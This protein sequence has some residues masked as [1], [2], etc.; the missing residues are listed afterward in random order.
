ME[1]RDEPATVK[2]GGADS[3]GQETAQQTVSNNNKSV[4]NM[5]QG[6]SNIDKSSRPEAIGHVAVDVS[7]FEVDVHEPEDDKLESQSDEVNSEV[8]LGAVRRKIPRCPGVYVEGTVQ[9]IPLWV[10]ADTGASRT[11]LAK[12]IYDN[13]DKRP[14]LKLSRVLLDQAGG[15]LLVD[16]GKVKISSHLETHTFPLEV[17]VADISRMRCC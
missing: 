12:S 2:L 7:E 15:S 1:H 5:I 4:D 11:V 14:S 16:Y 8:E 17:C 3:E 10:T 13:E 9:G 6:D